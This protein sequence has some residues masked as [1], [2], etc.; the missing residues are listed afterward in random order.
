LYHVTHKV[1]DDTTKK[2][3]CAR[4]KVFLDGDELEISDCLDSETSMYDSPQGV[5]AYIHIKSEKPIVYVSL[6]KI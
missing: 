1:I 3:L 2:V 5:E 4:I 6:A